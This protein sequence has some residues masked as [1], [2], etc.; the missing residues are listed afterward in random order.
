MRICSWNINS[1]R[2][3]LDLISE[4]VNII[5]PDVIAFQETKVR[6]DLFPKE[7]VEK[8]GYP[9]YC[10]NGQ[11]SYNGVCILSKFPI[12]NINILRLFNDDARHI[13]CIINDIEIH[14]FYVPAGGDE[15]SIKDNPKFFHKIEFLKSIR[16][17]F[18]TKK[19]KISNQNLGH[20]MLGDFN[21]APYEHDVWS[22]KSLKNTVSH[23]NL[24]RELLLEI[25]KEIGFVDLCR[26]F[27][28]HETKAYSWW[29]YRNRDWKKSNR[30]RRLDH[31]WADSLLVDNIRAYDLFKDARD[32]LKP[33]DHVPIYIDVSL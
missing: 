24:E 18:V 1:L 9:Y 26:K 2:L 28:S 11:K 16:D 14:N 20:I 25:K 7:Q 10:F 12:K 30:G 27:V 21:I 32:M 4:V 22:S 23:T 13:S 31:I 5:S 8:L 29:S 3:R 19:S 15:P 33:S 17:F 6:D